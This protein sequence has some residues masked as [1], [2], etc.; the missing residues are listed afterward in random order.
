MATEKHGLELNLKTN[1]VGV[2]KAAGKAAG[3]ASAGV[4]SVGSAASSSF[5]AAGAAVVV[6]NQG[7]ELA[8]K[9][10]E[11]FRATVGAA[12]E[13]SMEFRKV[14]DD[15][16][17]FFKDFG[18]EVNLVQARIGD[19]LLPVFRGFIEAVQAA[20][21]PLSKLIEANR[22]LIGTK[23]IEWLGS[24]SKMLVSGLATAV[25]VVSRTFYTLKA[26][27]GIVQIAVNET[28]AAII[29][30]AAWVTK[31]IATA[32]GVL[33]AKG[34][35]AAAGTA[36]DSMM[37]LKA[38]FE[39]SSAAAQDS[40]GKAGEAMGQLDMAI[41]KVESTANRVIGD[42]MVRGM[43]HV[44]TATKGATESIE[45]Q[46]EAI[47]KQTELL[48]QQQ[49]KVD[50]LA[51]KRIAAID[52]EADR[53]EKDA[54]A[55]DAKQQ[56]GA[57]GQSVAGAAGQALAGA[58][59]PLGGIAASFA[60]GNIAGGVAQSISAVAA[61]S[62]SFQRVLKVVNETFGRIVQ[63]LEP[64]IDI[65]AALAPMLIDLLLPTLNIL[66]K[67][68][69]EV[70]DIVLSIA[71]TLVRVWNGIINAIATVLKKIGSISI[72]GQKPL[73][74]LEKWGKKLERTAKISTD[75]LEA[76]QRRIKE[77]YDRLGDSV[78]DS[79]DTVGD[80]AD[81]MQRNL[82]N[83]PRTL[84]VALREFE[85]ADAASLAMPGAGGLAD[86]V[87]AAGGTTMN[88]DTVQVTSIANVDEVMQVIRDETARLGLAELGPMPSTNSAQ[89]AHHQPG[90]ANQY[91]PPGAL[92]QR[93]G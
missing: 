25:L 92:N 63:A 38:E 11:V 24:T 75:D 81:E 62:E 93:A 50:A 51:Q 85:A 6:F 19:A 70:A 10:I 87:A 44:R 77:G 13:R 65:V 49:G 27:A 33:G 89:T 64:V 12:I 54:R 26:S 59:G 88:V 16:S 71:T 36:R 15:M 52:A 60:T 91:I 69:V 39:R 67:V 41:A 45:E 90:L 7:L 17:G 73:G 53:F 8:K 68:F 35:A 76:A 14:G 40:V 5:S 86:G 23:L 61:E 78:G 34:I 43:E 3:A 9:G 28:F 21:G 32:A 31:A 48:A 74:A 84:K 66:S 1:L 56:A 30:G 37:G 2:L 82:L 72:A 47:A 58:A 79:A 22:K 29:E 55:L 4:A 57:A 20:I 42:A 80:A 18:R 46:N 83:V